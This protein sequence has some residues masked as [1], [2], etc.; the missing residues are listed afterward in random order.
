[1][2]DMY[3]LD[4]ASWS[5]EKVQQGGTRPNR[6]LGKH[7]SFHPAAASHAGHSMLAFGMQQQVVDASCTV[8]ICADAQHTC[9]L[10]CMCCCA[11]QAVKTVCVHTCLQDGE[12]ADPTRPHGTPTLHSFDLGQHKWSAVHTAGSI[13]F[14]KLEALNCCGSKLIAVGRGSSASGKSDG[15]MQVRVGTLARAAIQ[16]VRRA[17]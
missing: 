14:Q 7:L 1:M 6:Q 11:G 17:G 13:P 3:S 15:N 8:V 12:N 5:W 2:D 10:S 4:L 16:R 9:C